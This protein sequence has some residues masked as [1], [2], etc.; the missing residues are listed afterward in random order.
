MSQSNFQQKAKRLEKQF[1]QT[2][3]S[4][5]STTSRGGFVSEDCYGGDN[6]YKQKQLGKKL[7]KIKQSRKFKPH[8]GLE[9]VS[10]FRDLL[11]ILS[12]HARV[13]I[14]DSYLSKVEGVFALFINLQSCT[15]LSGI[16]SAIFLYVKTLTDKSLLGIVQDYIVKLIDEVPFSKQSNEDPEWI[17]FFKNVGDNWSMI[18]ASK[19]F[20]QFSKL[21]NVLVVL[22][23]CDASDLKF[24]FLGFKLFD[25]DVFKQHLNAYDFADAVF[26]TVSYFVEGTYRCYQFGNLRPLLV[27]DFKALDLTE[28]YQTVMLW[29]ELVQNGNLTSATQFTETDFIHKKNK[30]I[31]E[32]KN[33]L[34]SL[35]GFDKTIMTNNLFKISQMDNDYILKKISSGLR[36]APFGVEAVGD[37]SQGKTTFADQL[38]TALLTSAGLPTENRYRASLNS[39]DKFFS[40]WTS[41]MLVAIF[42]DVANEKIELCEKAPSRPIIDFCNNQMQY[43]PK[44]DLDSKGKCFIEPEIVVT[45]TNVKD[46]G[47]STSSNCPY[48]VQRRMNLIFTVQCKPEF[49]RV[50]HEPSG[51]AIPC[52]VDSSKV[53]AFYT[54]D[55]IYTAPMIDDIWN[56][57]VEQCIAPPN[58]TDV[59]SYVPIVWRGKQMVKVSAVEAINCAIEHYTAH[60]ANQEKIV[61]SMGKR[62]TSMK[63]CSFPD[64]PFLEGTCPVH[65]ES[66]GSELI[67]SECFEPQGSY[68]NGMFMALALR[69]CYNTVCGKVSS[70]SASFFDR[71]ERKATSVVYSEFSKFMSKWD[72]VFFIPQSCLDNEH[73]ISFVCWWYQDE[74]KRNVKRALIAYF[75]I[76]LLLCFVQP[77][78]GIA[79]FAFYYL[80]C[81]SYEK[82]KQKQL[83]L[84]ALTMRNG[85]IPNIV[86]NTRDKYAKAITATCLGLTALYAIACVYRWLK[87]N[88]KQGKLQ[89][90]TVEDVKQR[91]TEKSQW[92]VVRKANLP[93]SDASLTV[94]ADD[95][96]KCAIKNLRYASVKFGDSVMMSNV[97]FLTS[98]VFVIP[99]HYFD[100][101]EILT[102]SCYQD[103]DHVGSNFETVVSLKTSYVVPNTD[104]VLCY[105]GTGGSFKNLSKFL[106][107][108]R[109]I[110]SGPGVMAYR[111]KGGELITANAMLNACETSNGTGIFLGGNYGNL[112]INTFQGMCGAVWSTMTT[113]PFIAGFHL[114]GHAGTPEGCFG[115]LS[116][117]DF[118]AGVEFLKSVPGFTLT[119][120]GEYFTP[121]VLGVNI[122]TDKKMSFKSP[123][124]Y[125]PHNSQFQYFGSCVG[126]T[127][128]RSDVRRTPISDTLAFVC[129]VPNIWGAPKMQPEWFG[130]QTCLENASLPGKCF[131]PELL[132]SAVRDYRE[133]LLKLIASGMWNN[134]TPLNNHQN[135]NGIPGC[136]FIDAINLNTAI[137]YPLVGAKRKHVIEHEPTLEHPCNREFTPEIMGEIERVESFYLRGERAFTVAKAC[138]KD[139]ALP[140]AKEKVRIFYG[141][142]IALTFLIRKY[143]LPVLRF[144]QMNPLLSECAVGINSQG[145]EWDEFYTHAV[146][147]GEERLFGGDYGKYDQKLPSQLLLAALNVLISLAQQCDYTDQDIGVMRAMT[148]DIVYALIAFNGDL[149]GLQSG[150][151]ISGNSLTVILNGICG[152]LNLRCF[153]YTQYPTS[154]SFR[155]AVS[156]MTYGDDNIGS[157]S[158]EFPKFNIK[159]C[160]EFLAT[161][162]QIYT[163]PD[164]E[165]ELLPYLGPGDFEFLKRQNVYHEALGCNIGALSQKSIFKSLHCY[166]RPKKC[167]LTPL[168]ACATNIDG[169]LRE[170][171]CHGEEIYEQRREEMNIVAAEHGIQFMCAEL[172]KTYAQCVQ[173]WL[174]TYKL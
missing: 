80:L 26:G 125:L 168:E 39:G 71:I 15:T 50:I 121:K 21:L 81:F 62:Q 110:Q 118:N 108:S 47:A 123:M 42:D 161:Y 63:K 111:C 157:V 127:T 97:F 165:S 61:E 60:R 29:W 5:Q 126:E 120:S 101:S 129:N 67:C 141:N 137:G 124:N 86:K 114:G 52:G 49:Q 149:V 162:G 18:K 147:H 88:H 160:S 33:M 72:W 69:S 148:G 25:E 87:R 22:G 100:N 75:I 133:P 9:Q 167:A 104:F 59:G 53:R 34:P 92:A 24:D 74:I 65:F 169:A 2:K 155:D 119:G 36:K 144:L 14:P 68:Q 112:T 173:K 91:D 10:E 164:K 28:E 7:D 78:L 96:H 44:A 106:P 122:L 1:K 170:W 12:D 131:S 132:A 98:N 19:F 116:I 79:F 171:F 128:S 31:K 20:R 102:L 16:S 90:S 135:L 143:Y 45:T 83:F 54:I 150:T 58:I 117:E 93:V 43:A 35:T 82:S 77:L 139:E 84:D 89:P 27:N 17:S 166:L 73:F 70:D 8:S 103:G 41:D 99:K 32:M 56:I 3:K 138:K 13:K 38:V 51:A 55:G 6:H 4:M 145:P 159:G 95:L 48:A 76:S 151:H 57:T 153:F 85:A 105:S 115:S 134:I 172:D 140:I 23:M 130:W 136:R 109:I 37:S 154:V 30:V 152:S 156:I 174:D 11:T 163:M 107:L 146:K 40:N 142:P 113:A 94:K 64:C 46:L 66:Q 158:S